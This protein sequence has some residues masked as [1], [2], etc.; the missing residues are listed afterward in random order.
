MTAGAAWATIGGMIFHDATITLVGNR[1]STRTHDSAD[2]AAPAVEVLRS[3]LDQHGNHFR[4]PLPVEE[5]SWLDLALDSD[6]DGAAV[7]TFWR[8]KVPITIS[9]MVA[10]LDGA[11]DREVLRGLQSLILQLTRRMA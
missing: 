4:R 1:Y 6:G 9:G 8:G 2:L 5:F 10:G 11:A 3:M 7:A